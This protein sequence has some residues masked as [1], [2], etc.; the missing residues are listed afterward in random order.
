MNI[1]INEN[2]KDG[3]STDIDGR[4]KIQVKMPIQ[5]LTISYIGY[6]SLILYAP[7]QQP[8]NIQLRATAYEFE[9]VTVIAGENPAHR[10]IREVVKNRNLNNPE[11]MDSYKCRTYNKMSAGYILETEKMKAHYLDKDTSRKVIKKF[12]ENYSKSHETFSKHDL[13]LIETVSKM[14][15]IHNS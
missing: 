14:M 10:I 2:Q 12:Y 13:M 11:K 9:E 5:Q 4:F 15:A 3:V 7:F 6:E 1:L 8:L